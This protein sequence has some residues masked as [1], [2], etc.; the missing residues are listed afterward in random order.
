MQEQATSRST[1][2]SRFFAYFRESYAEM[3]KITWPTR[4]QTVRYAILIVAISVVVAA[5]F[6][7]LDWALKIGLEK[8]VAVSS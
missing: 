4:A 5:F 3:H 8:L 6:G 2:L 1:I 7:A